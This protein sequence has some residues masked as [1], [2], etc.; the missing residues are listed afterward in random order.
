VWQKRRREKALVCL[1]GC[2]LLPVIVVD[3]IKDITSASKLYNAKKRT[4]VSEEIA[5]YQSLTACI[6]SL[7]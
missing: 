4:A 1:K 2:L 7:M 6:R 3:L 5:V